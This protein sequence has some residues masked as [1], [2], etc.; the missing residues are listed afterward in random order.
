MENM[1]RFYFTQVP[2]SY[3]SGKANLCLAVQK[4]VICNAPF[5]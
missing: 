1:N 2:D 5:L 3:N 4:R